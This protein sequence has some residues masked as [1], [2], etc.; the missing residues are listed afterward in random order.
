MVSQLFPSPDLAE[1]THLEEGTEVSIIAEVA[2][3]SFQEFWERGKRRSDPPVHEAVDRIGF[4]KIEKTENPCLKK[5][6]ELIHGRIVGVA[7]YA[8]TIECRC[9]DRIELLPFFESLHQIGIG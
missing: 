6:M 2:A 4:V 7:F 5:E 3:Y 1:Q 8:S 9:I